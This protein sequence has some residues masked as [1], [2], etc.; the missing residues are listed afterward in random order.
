MH[1]TL[2]TSKLR[3]DSLEIQIKQLVFLLQGVGFVVP[4]HLSVQTSESQINH[5]IRACS[6][7]DLRKDL[8]ERFELEVP[9]DSLC[10]DREIVIFILQKLQDVAQEPIRIDRKE[11]SRFTKITTLQSWAQGTSPT[12]NSAYNVLI[13]SSAQKT[14]V[15]TNKAYSLMGILNVRFPAFPAE[16]LP[17]ALCRLWDEKIIVSNDISIFNWSGKYFGS[18]IQGR[19][20]YPSCIEAYQNHAELMS[21][22]AVRDINK[23]VLDASEDDRSKKKKITHLTI[24]L[25]LGD[26]IKLVG[27]LDHDVL[28]DELIESFTDLI[29]FIKQLPFDS[30]KL[31]RVSD[32]LRN[33]REKFMNLSDRYEQE[34]ENTHFKQQP[35]DLENGAPDPDECKGSEVGSGQEQEESQRNT[36]PGTQPAREEIVSDEPYDCLE[37]EAQTPLEEE[38]SQKKSRLGI[39]GRIPK[40]PVEI[41]APLNIK[42]PKLDLPRSLYYKLKS[43]KTPDKPR[44]PSEF[45]KIIT[46][47]RNEL[48]ESVMNMGNMKKFP[49]EDED[50]NDTFS[51]ASVSGLKPLPVGYG[52]LQ[53]KCHNLIV[54]GSSGISGK[55]DIQLIAVSMLERNYLRAQIKKSVS[56]QNIE[57][58]CTVSTGF[59][60][61]LVNFNCDR[62]I[63]KQQLDMTEVVEETF[64]NAS[65][66]VPMSDDQSNPLIKTLIKLGDDDSST[67]GTEKDSN[68][69]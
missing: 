37:K 32:E 39:I 27:P 19:S 50:K 5:A 45:E 65:E 33:I 10:S 35:N 55:F 2:V 7:Q 46:Q 3:V 57:S 24:N 11:I 12:D 58:W 22:S 64:L 47:F 41:S 30:L 52:A 21:L 60:Y 67:V 40:L 28:D 17:K 63:V 36:Q 56:G 38:R 62:D 34:N 29:G 8:K 18:T 54:I 13:T 43:E 51:A 15:L 59:A 9:P 61:I 16:G 23:L 69:R 14:E 44:E 53:S 42:T 4:R 6:V 25:L 68:R 48:K 31:E 26:M 66:T 1:Q 49:S 20:L